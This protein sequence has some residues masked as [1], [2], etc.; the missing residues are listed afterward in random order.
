MDLPITYFF[1]MF[2]IFASLGIGI[3][4][5]IYK[6]SFR[7]KITLIVMSL[8]VTMFFC[9]AVVFRTEFNVFLFGAACIGYGITAHLC[10]NWL[11]K[12][13]VN[14]LKELKNCLEALSKGDFTQKISTTRN[15]E[16]AVMYN[17]VNAMIDE[18]SSLINDIKNNCANNLK[19]ADNLYEM[20]QNMSDMAGNTSERTNVVA[21]TAANL[22]DNMRI[23]SAAAEQVSTNMVIVASAI[24]EMTATVDEIVTNSDKA[25]IITD[26]GVLQTKSVYNKIAELGEAAKSISKVTETISDISEQTNLLALNATIEAARAGDTGKGF[27]VV[28]G[29]IKELARQTAA[30]THEIKI[31]VDNVQHTADSTVSEIERI[32]KV[33]HDE[34][35]IITF[36]A[37]AVG[38][39]ATTTH[40]I[41]FNV[42]NASQGMNEINKSISESF[43]L[44]E[45]IA[46]HTSDIKQE[47]QKVSSASYELKLNTEVL[48]DHEKALQQRVSAFQILN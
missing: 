7:M 12:H 13:L 5:Y 39:Q 16:F 33:I 44:S 31:I 28:A 24:E 38:D 35:K 6:W 41:A 19:M 36:I 15:D 29:E 37:S 17:Q 47:T 23:I 14:P 4:L 40:E 21:D 9:A 2:V 11:M 18:A 34:N 8:S 32:T 43:V 45:N 1:I 48:T 26:D 10:I 42:G 30:A 27:A 20:S 46:G 25:R 3:C 22:S